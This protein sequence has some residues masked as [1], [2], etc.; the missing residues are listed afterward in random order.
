MW[1]LLW[2][3]QPQNILEE[4]ACLQLRDVTGRNVMTSIKKRSIDRTAKF[5]MLALTLLVAGT[6]P[7]LPSAMADDIECTG[8]LRV[9]TYD[10]IVVPSG[11]CELSFGTVVKGNIK[12][13]GGNFFGDGIEIVGNLQAEEGASDTVLWSSTVG[14]NVQVQKTTGLVD[15]ESN[16]IREDVQITDKPSG[17]IYVDNNYIGEDFQAWKNTVGDI[18]VLSNT[19]GEDLQEF[20]NTSNYNLIAGNTIGGNFQCKEN[21]VPPQNGGSANTTRGNSEDQCAEL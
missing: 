19:I 6:L 2:Q 16:Y 20:D 4:C 1:S 9:D 3:A 10:N 21:F 12:Q 13:T 7:Y 15:L 11:N 14:G 8:P 5:G 17:N 18:I